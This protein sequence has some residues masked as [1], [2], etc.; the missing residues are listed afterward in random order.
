[1]ILYLQLAWRNIWR[2]KRR[3]LISI[4]SIFFAVVLALLM[5]S[6]QL[7]SYEYMIQNAVKLSTGYL[8]VHAEGYWDKRSIDQSFAYDESLRATLSS[9]ENVTELIPR[10]QS[11]ALAA[12]DDATRGAMVNGIDPILEDQMNALQ[13]NV[14]RGSYLELG[15]TG[16]LISEGLSNHLGFDVGDTLVLY[17]QGYHGI[18]AAGKY[19]VEGV[20]EFLTP[21]LNAA[22]VYLTLPVAQNLYGMPGLVNSV[23]V[24]V[25][26]PRHQADVLENV[27]SRVGDRYEVM[28]WDE[29]MPDLVQAIEV[30]NAGGILMLG[31]LYVVIGFGIFGTVMMMTIERRK[32]FGVLMAV[33][34]HRRTLILTTLTETVLLS[35]LGVIAGAAVSLPIMVYYA[36]NPIQL[37][38]ELAE[39]MIR[40]GMDPILPL[41]MNPGIIGAQM[42]V[43]LLLAVVSVTYPT[44]VL[45]N[46]EPVKAMRA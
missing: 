27:K 16:V 17:G 18:I 20:V 46:L 30:D 5:R 25:G 12:S 3:T 19:P 2:N 4:S 39:V 1:M 6:M 15:D 42:L 10:L 26:H 31:I 28:G 40:F 43:V 9:V 44:R 22:T 29:M 37:T 11:F 23:S 21:D 36:R 38:G 45:M 32:E 35:L 24:M 13:S 34:M 14:V 8:Q 7:G 33:G 41:S